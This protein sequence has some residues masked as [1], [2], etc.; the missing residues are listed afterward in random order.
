MTYQEI[1][2]IYR[3]NKCCMQFDKVTMLMFSCVRSC[4][5]LEI[6]INLSLEYTPI[7]SANQNQG[8]RHTTIQV[9]K[10]YIYPNYHILF[11]T[12]LLE[13]FQTW[14]TFLI[15]FMEYYFNDLNHTDSWHHAQICS[16]D[17]K[18][19]MRQLDIRPCFIKHQ[20]Y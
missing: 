16:A 10:H 13:Y 5:G 7:L 18:S 3:L 6:P 20:A 14:T 1:I 4:L 9:N 8:R 19:N 11:K 15:A 17:M 2:Y 12:K